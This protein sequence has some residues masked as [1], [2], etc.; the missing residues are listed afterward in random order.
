MSSLE[1][2]LEATDLR[3]RYLSADESLRLQQEFGEAIPPRLLDAMRGHRLIGV[4]F[5][6]SEV[7]DASGLGVEMRWL[8]V[9]QL[10]SEAKDAYPGRA[11]LA[12]GFIP[13]SSCLLGSGDPYF[14]RS[15]VASDES[16][17]VRIPHG[18]VSAVGA[19]VETQVETVAANLVRFVEAAAVE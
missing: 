8:D 10:I 4:T 3:G 12:L 18:A 15:G 11:A 19:L 6:L 2:V 14:L 13:I 16:E 1:E 17:V 7:D 5:V 9:D